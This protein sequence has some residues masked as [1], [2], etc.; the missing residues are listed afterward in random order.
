M[1]GMI[2]SDLPNG[3]VGVLLDSVR[4]SVVMRA[5]EYSEKVKMRFASVAKSN[6]L[7][8]CGRRNT[9]IR[10]LGLGVLIILLT[11]PGCRTRTWYFQRANRDARCL[12]HEKTQAK[13]WAVPAN[14]SLT[15]SPESR[16]A[17]LDC[18]VSPRLPCPT[19]TLYAYKL[20]ELRS[21]L[22]KDSEDTGT[23]EVEAAD[24]S[25]A[26][27]GTPIPP[28]A[29]ENLPTQC[30]K[31]MSEF[32]SIREEAEYASES[33]DGFNAF[34]RQFETEDD[35]LTLEDI[36]DI[37]LLNSREY[38]TQKENLFLVSLTLA[39][40]RFAYAN[41]FSN[42]GNGSGLGFTHNRILGI[43]ENN[44]SIPSRVA[45][46]KL[47]VT[48][49]DL[50]AS[51][52]N[53]ILLTFNGPTGFAADVSSSVLIDFT[54]PL[55]QRDVRFEGL[56]QAER[57]VV[58]AARDFA[59]FRKQFFV[60]F[61]SIYYR[62]ILSYRQ[63]EIEAQNYF[64]LVRAFNQAGA[65]FQ[66][67]FVPRVQVDQVEQS[68][69]GGRGSLIATCNGVEQS[70]DSLKISMG[71]PTETQ[72]NLDLSEL[73]E[74]TRLDQLS[75]SSD[76]S[77]RVLRRIETAFERP[78][79]GVLASAASVLIERVLEAS[80]LTDRANS[81]NLAEL[82]IARAKFLVDEAR[83]ASAEV[84]AGLQQEIESETPSIQ[85][86]FQR[87]IAH[88]R[89][90]MDVVTR[91]L[92]LAELSI[93]R[94]QILDFAE[95]QLSLA[96]RIDALVVRYES[97]FASSDG[98]LQLGQMPTLVKEGDELRSSLQDLIAN[99]YQAV[100]LT[101]EDDP[102]Q[103]LKRIVREVELL[104]ETVKQT[105][106]TPD[107]GLKRID[108]D[109]D[110]A[111]ATAL[112]LRF[113]LMNQRE[114]AVDDWR[115]IKLAADNLKSILDINARQVFRTDPTTN[116]PFNFS[117]DDSTT[118]LGVTFDAPLNRF[119]QRNT[120]RASLI[121]YQRALR[122]LMQ[123][124]DNIKFSVRNDLRNLA[125]DREQYLIAVASA[126]LAFERVVSTSLEFRLGTSGVS[127]RDFLEAQTAYTNA[128][129]SVASRHID[130]ILDRTQLFLDL[131]LLTVDETGFWQDLRDED[132]LPEPAYGLPAWA[133]PVYG[134]LPCVPYSHEMRYLMER[135]PV[136]SGSL[137]IPK[138]MESTQEKSSSA[139]SD[140]AEAS[141]QMDDA[142][143]GQP[144]EISIEAPPDELPKTD[145]LRN[146][147]SKEEEQKN[148]PVSPGLPLA[149]ATP[150][151][152]S[153]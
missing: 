12:L 79:R 152:L 5:R 75:V 10:A 102:E 113:E 99:I 14:F 15:P 80:L 76:L 132:V 40:E 117:F 39:Q 111:M 104:S 30:L 3:E 50:L 54:Q 86:I 43:T 153:Q 126:A 62:L 32:K 22:L 74:L 35:R 44:L 124:E 85:I 58:Y 98:E 19:P 93:E 70:L 63:I 128:L 100:G 94:E 103:D 127:A 51:F 146:D 55:L 7:H 16:L 141:L 69:L 71:I 77:N 46:D 137:P 136:C 90:Q 87:S 130:Y 1:I 144:E 78:D 109:P 56:T 28:S 118:Q 61:A 29:W 11:L 129:S 31:R 134:K 34:D 24:E 88:A 68:L 140:L 38:Q 25:N 64:S 108:I 92:E 89:Y 33:F 73:N 96:Q 135:Q 110:D 84:L 27:R 37:A 17:P 26:P 20:P 21:R 42:F 67:D 83:I 2:T 120:F 122:N 49:G 148:A 145:Q 101:V 150:L 81:D 82:Q 36:V 107:F 151:Q 91:Q 41:K 116:Q 147:E 9:R 59:R 138:P 123:L 114:Q 97:L 95:Q 47:L 4:A 8:A 133:F 106:S 6:W 139:K 45:G 149:P 112:V 57:N 105:L 119:A 53:N 48:G 18:L 66:R 72:L 121:T 125:L 60:D 143:S 115:R 131:E 52:A 142:S 23:E 13:P 65:E